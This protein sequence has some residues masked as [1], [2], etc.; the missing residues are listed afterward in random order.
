MRLPVAVFFA[1]MTAQTA[2]FGTLPGGETVDAY[3]LRN[4][5]GVEVRVMTYG[6][7]VVS[8]RTPDRAGRIDD[9]V[10]GF[11]RIDDY[12]TKARYFGSIAGRYANRIRHGR[13]TLDGV[14]FQLAA[15]NGVNHLH[16]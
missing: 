9:V 11:D 4:A 2:P 1:A 13:F 15:N 8:V 6:A 7:T 16:G 12:L 3:T 14:A 10:L 5:H